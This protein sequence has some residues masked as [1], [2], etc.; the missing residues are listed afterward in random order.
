[1]ATAVGRRTVT[2]MLTAANLAGRW[3]HDRAHQFFSRAVWNPHRLGMT[4]AKTVVAHL[5]PDQTRM[6]VS[7]DDTLFRRRGKKVYQARWAHD[8][9]GRGK[10]KTGVRQHL[11]DP[12][13]HRATPLPEPSRS[14]FRR[15]GHCGGARAPPR[16]PGRPSP[17]SPASPVRCPSG[18]ST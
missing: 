2:G 4:L 18:P 17:W 15:C 10:D 5:L 8:G 9:S 3:P 6:V 16:A 12:R 7:V 13:D 11:G 1:M 14:C